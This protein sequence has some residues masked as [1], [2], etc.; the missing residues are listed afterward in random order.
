MNHR[1]EA[2]AFHN[3]VKEK[4]EKQA[5]NDIAILQEFIDMKVSHPI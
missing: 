2:G 5:P 3:P 1:A 4:Q